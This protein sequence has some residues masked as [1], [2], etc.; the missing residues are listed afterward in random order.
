MNRTIY[1]LWLGP[2]HMPEE[3]EYFEYEWGRLNPGWR[4]VTLGED[5]FEPF[6]N[7][8]VLAD[9]KRRDGGKNGIELFVQ[10][11][12]VLGYEIVHRYGGVYA[13]CD[14]QPLRPFPE[15]ILDRPFASLEN[16][17]GDVVNAI[18]G[19][20]EPR[21]PVWGKCI[22][23]LNRRYWENPTGEMNQTTGPAVVTAIA[24]QRPDLLRIF[25][26]STFNS[27]HWSEIPRGADASELLHLVPED[28][29]A[30]H[31]WGHRRDGR[32]NYVETAT[33]G[34]E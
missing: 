18:F 1:R 34:T 11:A 14:L 30:V 15:D 3:Y 26:Q 22:R 4:V 25:P 12:D 27:V 8:D 5:D 20:P 23:E 24:R 33:G 9:L 2:R 28:A 16:D 32:T 21:A 10:T 13:N 17:I 29:I 7:L 31:H 19:A 6:E